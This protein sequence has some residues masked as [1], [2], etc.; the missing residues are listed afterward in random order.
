LQRQPS[1][2]F[3]A[4]VASRFFDVLRQAHD[5]FAVCEPRYATWFAAAADAVLVRYRIGRVAADPPGAARAT[6]P[7]GWDGIAY[8]RLHGSPRTYW[9][10]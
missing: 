1:L 6:H 5:G 9:S 7:G 3:E 10:S 4:R 8:F 2:A